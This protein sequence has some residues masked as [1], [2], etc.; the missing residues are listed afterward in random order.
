MTDTNRETL[1]DSEFAKIL[2]AMQRACS[3]REYCVADI[4]KK[5]QRHK[6]PDSDSAKIIA[7]LKGDNFINELRYAKA[8]VTD[9]SRLSGWGRAKI[10]WALKSKQ[11]DKEVIE[12]AISILST[13]NVREQLRKILA[14]RLKTLPLN[15]GASDLSDYYESESV[16]D[17]EIDFG[18]DSYSGDKELSPTERWKQRE[19]QRAKLIRFGLSRGFEYD[20]V[21]SVVGELLR[22]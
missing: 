20:M 12:N 8:F 7:S 1:L 6:V 22:N 11:I 15:S 9:K 13:D 19:K 5:L 3:V 10:I 14:V 4:L 21:L 18:A 16:S 17:S 2:A